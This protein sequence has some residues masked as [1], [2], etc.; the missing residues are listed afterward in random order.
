[1]EEAGEKREK[2]T[3][4]R[5]SGCRRESAASDLGRRLKDR[6]EDRNGSDVDGGSLE[7]P[8]GLSMAEK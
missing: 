5:R 7:E 2:L 1:M 3:R 6:T 8:Y 4:S